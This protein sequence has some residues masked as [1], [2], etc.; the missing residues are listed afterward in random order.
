MC[1]NDLLC[2]GVKPLY[3]LDYMALDKLNYDR[4]LQILKGIHEGCKIAGCKLVGGET[5]EMGNVYNFNSF[6]LAG[7]A[8]G[9]VLK[10][11]ILPKKINRG[12]KIYGLKSNGLHSNGFS[13]V[14]KILRH[15]NYDIDE[16]LK[17]TKIYTEVLGLIE[18]YAD[19]ILGIAHI[20][21]GGLHENI[22]RILSEDLSYNITN[23]LPLPE[24]FN[25]IKNE[26]EIS[27]DELK[28]TF[29]CGIGMV[30]ITKKDFSF[31]E[32]DIIYMGNVI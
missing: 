6:D 9:T 3:F 24:I 12:D 8:V 26:G 16:I 19:N 15:S 22:I 2:H 20:T 14:R 30:I 21:G 28:K 18:K 1:V 10:D 25:W 29:N 7:F 4:D 13:L 23:R 31:V 5:A 17:P 11:N 32:E 27:E